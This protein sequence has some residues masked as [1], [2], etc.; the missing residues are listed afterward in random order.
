[1]CVPGG[2]E[3]TLQLAIDLVAVLVSPD[4]PALHAGETV[5]KAYGLRS[6]ADSQPTI[7]NEEQRPSQIED[8]GALIGPQ[9]ER[10]ARTCGGPSAF[11]CSPLACGRSSRSR[12]LSVG[13]RRP[14]TVVQRV[15]PIAVRAKPPDLLEE[16]TPH[17]VQMRPWRSRAV[18]NETCSDASDIASRLTLFRRRLLRLLCFLCVLLRFVRIAIS[19]CD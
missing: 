1:M 10:V 15:P 9:G 16:I 19:A 18:P 14:R 6:K 12:N 17:F 7:S 2:H 3:F 11:E 4:A 5:G 8:R 13:C